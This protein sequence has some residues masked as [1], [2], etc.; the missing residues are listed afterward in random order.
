M[1]KLL[2]LTALLSLK[3]FAYPIIID[4]PVTHVFVPTGFDDNDN[5][6]VVV[7]GEFPGP[8]FSRNTV[9]V[10]KKGKS[11]DI[12]VTAIYNIPGG[13]EKCGRMGIP[14]KE[15]IN[16]GQLDLGNYKIT[17]NDKSP[18]ELHDKI[19]VEASEIQMVDERI[20]AN[21]EYIE[22]TKNPN[23]FILHGHNP[24]DCLIFSDFM[25]LSN[26]KDTIS[27][28]PI[29]RKTSDLCPMKMTEFE[30]EVTVDFST[31]KSSE[32]LLHTRVMDGRSVNTIVNRRLNN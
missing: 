8:C 26:D 10:S 11:I 4:A 9:D 6:E 7:S 29:M 3:T 22:Q 1:N 24:S 31:I 23:K 13:N 16:L 18:Y 19:S 20:Y 2:L 27:I 28:L 12:K 15:V 30:M 17:V 5:V 14:F 25:F 32:V 21:I